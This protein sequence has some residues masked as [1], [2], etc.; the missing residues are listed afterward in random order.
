[1][2]ASGAWHRALLCYSDLL[3][4]GM[5]GTFNGS[6]AFG[7]GIISVTDGAT[8]LMESTTPIYSGR[9]TLAYVH[10][11]NPVWDPALARPPGWAALTDPSACAEAVATAAPI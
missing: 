7:A 8:D 5:L 3:D 1:V 6:S 11:S 9:S 2:L 4:D 10:T